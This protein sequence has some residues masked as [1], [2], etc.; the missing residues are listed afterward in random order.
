M[1][2]DSGVI[3]VSWKTNRERLNR[4]GNYNQHQSNIKPLLDVFHADRHSRDEGKIIVLM[5]HSKVS[6]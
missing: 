3:S 2:T 1:T 4:V 5:V 6:S